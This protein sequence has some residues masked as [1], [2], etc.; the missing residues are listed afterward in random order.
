MPPLTDRQKRLI[1]RG[2]TGSPKDFTW[3][4]KNTD[5]RI[6]IVAE[7]DSWFAYPPKG[8]VFGKRAN[9]ID[10]IASA[11]RRT[12]KAN[13]LRLESNGDEAIAMV[14]GDQKHQLAELLEVNGSKIHFL[15]FSGGGNDV[16]GKWDMERLLNEYQ[17][18]FTAKDCIN[19][20]RFNRKLQ[21]VSLAYQE[22]IELCEDYSPTT[23]IITHTY[24]AVTPSK[25]GGTF[26]W[27]LIKTKPWI[28]PYLVK[29]NIPTNLHAKIADILLQA[30]RDQLK[31]IANRPKNRGKFIVVDTYGTLRPGHGSDWI[32]EIHPTSS[33]FKR[34]TKLVYAK[35]RALENSLPAFK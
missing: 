32:N 5:N 21:R 6:G 4:C 19:T 24:D 7:G 14:S 3:L 11:V 33:G 26:L 29:K 9:I 28:Y 34:I 10:W 27:G 17:P 25:T 35:M 8:L 20:T 31:V 23:R 15:L 12:K 22:L 30:L 16:V 13:L 1:K 2:T 18:G